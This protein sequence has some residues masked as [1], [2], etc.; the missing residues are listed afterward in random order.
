MPGSAKIKMQI[1]LLFTT[2]NLHFV[3]YFVCVLRASAWNIPYLESSL[4][5]NCAL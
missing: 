5:L 4:G 2:A 3:L 1:A